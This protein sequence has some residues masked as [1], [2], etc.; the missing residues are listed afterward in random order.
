MKLSK[1]FYIIFA[2]LVLAC[3]PKTKEIKEESLFTLLPSSQ[4]NIDFRNDVV[5]TPD[6]NIFTYRNFFNGG[7]VGIGDVNNDGRPDVFFTSN[8]QKN[9]LYLNMGNFKFQDVSKKAGIEGIHMWHTGVTMTDVNAD[10][11]LD[12]YVCNSGEINGDNR[13]NELYINQK[14]DSFKEE[15][16]K[17]GLDDK[18]L[19]THAAFFDY[20]HDGDLDCYVLN[21]SYRPI[22][23]FGYKRNEYRN[24]RSASGGDRLYRNDSQKFVD[25]SEE[26]GIYGSEIGFGL[27]LSVGD[28]NN[29]GWDDM[30]ISNDFFERDYLYINQKNG[31][32]KEVIQS[33]MEHISLA[34][35]GSDIADINNDGYLDVFTTDMLPEHDVRLKTTIKFEDFDVHNAK[36]NNDFHHQFTQ[37]CLQLNN[38]DGTFSE[39]AAYARIEATDWS[40]GALS[41]DFDNDG[42]KDFFVSNGISKDL[43]NQDFLNYFASNEVMG[44]MQTGKLNF[45]NMLDTMQSNPISN[46]AYLNQK[47]VTFKNATI[48]LG[49]STPSFSNGAA[50]GDLD[51]DGDLDLVVNNEN[52]NAFVYQNNSI[53]KYKTNYLKVV[54]KG[55]DKN[56]LG[57]GSRVTVYENGA[58]QILIQMPN[59]GF[60]SS[61][62]PTLHFGV[63]STKLVDSVV[64]WWPSMKKQTITNVKANTTLIL[65]QTDAKQSL[66]ISDQKIEPL[67]ENITTKKLIGK[68]KH[69]ENNY[70]DFD[71]ERLIP[72]MLST[73]GP[74]LAVG[75]VNGD[76]L[77]D[78]FVGSSSGDTAKIFIQQQNGS[79]AQTKQFAFALD[80]DFEDAEA[81]FMDIDQ[82]QDVDLV[83]ASGGNQFPTGSLYQ[84]VRFYKN[85]GKG[86]FTRYLQ[87]VSSVFANASCIRNFDYDNDGDDDIFVGARSITNAYGILP[88]SFLFKNEGKGVFKDVTP[89]VAPVLSNLGMI[90]DCEVI[91]VDGDGVEELVAVGD[92]MSVTILKF[93]N[94]QIQAT[95]LKNTSGWWN[96]ILSADIDSDGDMDLIAGN[97]GLNSKL[98]VDPDHPAELYTAD[99]DGNKM[100]DCIAQYY[101]TDGKP[102]LHNLHDDLLKQIPM[103]KKRYLLY[104][105]YAGKSIHDLF[106]AKELSNAT[107]LYVDEVRSCIFRNDGKGNFSKEILPISAQLSPVYGILVSDLNNDATLDIFLGGNFYGLKPE[108]GRYDASYGVVCLGINAGKEFITVSPNVSGLFIRG[109]VRDVKEIQT[110]KSKVIL[111]SRNNETLQLFQKTN[112]AQ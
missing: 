81:I 49:L 91:D 105:S 82:D 11:W 31:K 111:I 100:T 97:S 24:I 15:A 32:F 27:G 41:F 56:T 44:Q 65:L 96:C 84:L 59:R 37:N 64:V 112:E 26:A 17:Y 58:K 71:T 109:E 95:K 86:I 89:T 3:S 48:P 47:N 46:Y 34:S 74:K 7:G 30:Y 51:G 60:Q 43:T 108:I 21:N 12:I 90:T 110:I 104:E 88:T 107:K 77:D 6:F 67:V 61:V 80:K 52:M 13:A 22:E 23:S 57:I 63:D 33:S 53:E 54:L 73:E 9:K 16:E 93:V 5:Y 29:D 62:D 45:K 72:K 50:Y 70:I 99:F 87:N 18:G 35:M 92:W 42:W 106:S 8:Q 102:Y 2:A 69:Y 85:D 39:I 14:D 4:T 68:T 28:L 40:W 101:K 36:L 20:D 1:L 94:S 66:T 76:K 78:F 38:G 98:R 55:S 79:F 75:D 103:L 25:V 83:M 19:S 10:G